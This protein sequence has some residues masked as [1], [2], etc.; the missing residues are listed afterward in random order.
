MS[1]GRLQCKGNNAACVKR[2]M[3][4]PSGVTMHLQAILCLS[5]LINIGRRSQINLDTAAIKSI[6]MFTIIM[7]ALRAADG[8]PGPKD[9]R[10]PATG[11]VEPASQS[12]ARPP[13]SP[14]RFLRSSRSGPGQVRDAAAGAHRRPIGDGCSREFRLFAAVVLSGAIGLRGRRSCRLSA[15][16]ACG[17]KQA[18][19]LTVEVL[20]FIGELR[21]KEPSIRLPD[22]VKRIQKRFRIKVHPR[23]IERSLLR[24]Q[25]NPA[26]RSR[27]INP[28]PNWIWL[29][30]TNN[31]VATPSASPL[32]AAKAWASRFFSDAE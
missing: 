19:K 20:T 28:H 1:L 15:A 16:Q 6:I 31:Y 9:P 26:E 18:H 4:E 5:F 29:S 3:P 22:L 12:G 27:M 2:I 10:A 8:R 21:Q 30:T 14:G 23:S 13:V 32:I 24:H 17:P 25:K 11:N 7:D